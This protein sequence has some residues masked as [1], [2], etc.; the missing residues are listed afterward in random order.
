M[1]RS[2]AQAAN[3]PH[4]P[5]DADQL[6]LLLH[7]ASQWVFASLH[8]QP[9]EDPVTRDLIRDR[10]ALPGRP[11]MLLQFGPA[12]IAASTARRPPGDLS[13]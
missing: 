12:A 2:R 4:R 3:R 7:A 5:G 8:T 10:L 11:Q 13:P 9:L 1:V 6:R